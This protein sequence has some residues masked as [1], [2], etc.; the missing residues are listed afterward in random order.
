[1]VQPPLATVNPPL[2]SARII[3]KHTL[4]KVIP[5]LRQKLNKQKSKGQQIHISYEGHDTLF[6]IEVPVE[7]AF[8]PH[9]NFISHS[10]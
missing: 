5:T 10:S 9:F 8:K 1:M 3:P 7:F 4:A 6:I 2:Y